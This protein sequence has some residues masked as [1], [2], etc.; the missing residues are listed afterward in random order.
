VAAL[1]TLAAAIGLLVA[2]PTPR[3]DTVIPVDP[4]AAISKAKS[5]PGFTVRLPQPLP[6]GWQPNSA[7]FQLTKD[8]P[9]LHIGYLAPDGGYVGL[10][11]ADMRNVRRYVTVRSAG[12]VFAD[13]RTINGQVWVHLTS[14]RKAQDS[15]AWFGPHGVV[16]VTG[17]A[18]VANLEQ[19]A[20]SLHLNP[21]G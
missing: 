3:A 15:L 2:L 10:E 11:Q 16:M 13:L 19:L 20:A 1:A 14:D 5:T 9:Q 7:R 12:N 21:S 17:T 8:G 4:S 6:A 18:S